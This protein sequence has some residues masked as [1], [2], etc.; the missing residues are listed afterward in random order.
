[1]FKFNKRWNPDMVT[2]HI[3]SRHGRE[4]LNS[5]RYAAVY[6]DVHAA[7]ARMFG[8][9]KAT[10]EACGID[11]EEVRRYRRWSK[12]KVLSEVRKLKKDGQSLNSKRIQDHH[13]PLY[14]AAVKR[15]GS[16]N[17][18]LAASGIDHK[19]VMLRRGLSESEIRE[20]VISLHQRG[21]DLAYP[22]MRRSHDRLLAAA[23]R[24]LGGGSWAEARRR[25]GVR[26]NFRRRMRGDA[27]LAM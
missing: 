14:Q 6:P 21:V 7:G 12:S 10:I 11:Y 18:T 20:A 22:G 24:K 15:F 17:E 3:I 5:S 1:M 4:P 25:C 2:S 19:R 16:W 9:W 26:R 27:L 13:R 23:S 8:T